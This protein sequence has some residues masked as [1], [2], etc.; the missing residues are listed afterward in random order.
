[1]KQEVMSH[2]MVWQTAHLVSA[3]MCRET[4][5]LHHC[6][7][8]KRHGALSILMGERYGPEVDQNMPPLDVSN[9]GDVYVNPEVGSPSSSVMTFLSW[10]LLPL[11]LQAAIYYLLQRR[12]RRSSFFP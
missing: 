12:F 10:S 9:P 11:A 7:L 6:M 5:G 4:R 3:V 8:Q 2:L 1:M